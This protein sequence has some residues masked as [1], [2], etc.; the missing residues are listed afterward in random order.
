VNESHIKFLSSPQWAQMLES[1]LLPWVDAAGDLGDDVLEIGPGPGLTTDLLARRVAH[2]TAI[3]VDPGLAAALGER[4]D[5]TNVDVIHG[6][7][8]A[9]TLDDDRFSTVT[10]FSVL[11]HLPS[12]ADQDRLF[13]EIGRLLRPG[14]MFVGVDSLDSEPIRAGHDGDTFVPVD[15]DRLGDRLAP[16]GLTVTNL[17]RGDYQFRFVATKPAL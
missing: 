6:D 13:A 1:D 15:P 14:G 16:A 9:S 5:G 7:A 8:T 3:E 4:F 2:L 10:C 11:H 17:D 12:A